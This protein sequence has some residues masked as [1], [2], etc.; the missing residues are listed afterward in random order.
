MESGVEQG[1]E[2]KGID[3]DK[4]NDSCEDKGEMFSLSGKAGGEIA[5]DPGKE[6]HC[7]DYGSGRIERGT[8]IED[9]SLDENDLQHHESESEKAEI[10]ESPELAG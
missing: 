3:K 2:N 6:E 8:E 5:A 1:A 10:E 9:E 4:N 7:G